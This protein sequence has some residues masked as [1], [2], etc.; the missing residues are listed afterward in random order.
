LLGN[1]KEVTI[2]FYHMAEV[3]EM[4]LDKSNGD[5]PMKTDKVY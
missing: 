2:T 1:D 3:M 5:I 4:I